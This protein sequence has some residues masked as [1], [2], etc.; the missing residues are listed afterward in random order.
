MRDNVI[1]RHEPLTHQFPSSYDYGDTQLLATNAKIMGL[2]SSEAE[3]RRSGFE[4][5]DG[6]TGE[7]NKD[8]SSIPASKS[9]RSPPPEVAAHSDLC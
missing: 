4:E 3:P 8:S 5:V 1:V 7:I 9:A 2:Q 6:S